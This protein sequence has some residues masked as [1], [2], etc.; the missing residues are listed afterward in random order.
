MDSILHFSC[1]CVCVCLTLGSKL[2]DLRVWRES[3]KR[4]RP[5]IMLSPVLRVGDLG[6]GLIVIFVVVFLTILLCFWG[7]RSNLQGLTCFIGSAV[8]ALLVVIMVYSPKED[9]DAKP[10]VFCRF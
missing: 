7:H 10:E 4:C 6:D 1:V 9:P 2:G 5:A 8:V 3:G